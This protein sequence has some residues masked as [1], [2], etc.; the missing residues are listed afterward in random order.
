MKSTRYYLLLIL[1]GLFLVWL[2]QVMARP[3]PIG[4]F[5][6]RA[7]LI[8]GTGILA[9]GSM[10]VAMMLAV[11]PVVLENTLNGLDKMY[12]L[13]KWLGIS[14]LVFAILHWS[15]AKAPRWIY[16]WDLFDLG[17]RGNRPVPVDPGIIEQF[18]H[19]QRHLAERVG[20]V[21]FYIALVLIILALL[22]RFPYHLFFKTHHFLAF[23]YLALVFHAVL[24]IRFYYWSRPIGI[25]MALLMIA[26][27]ISALIVIFHGIG[28][29][30]QARGKVASVERYEDIDFLSIEIDVAPEM[31]WATHQAGQ[32]AFLSFD[33]KK[34]AHPFTI[35]SA[36]RGDHR[37]RFVIKGLG[38]YTRQMTEHLKAGDAVRLE[39]PY[40]RF[41][42][43]GEKSR[44]IWIA[45]GIGITPFMARL[46]ALAQKSDGRTID[47]FFCSAVHNTHFVEEISRL[48]E[49]AKVR[50]HV[51]HDASD[52]FLD[53]A[54]LTQIV[55]EWQ[56]GS[57]WFCGPARFGDTLKNSLLARGL[58]ESQFHQELF[59]M[60]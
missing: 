2:L 10:S 20:E 8:Q 35:A 56:E 24:L 12:R 28:K 29:K 49:A 45:G 32:F 7:L 1:C 43:G 22:R 39:G 5:A 44:Q 27:G 46:D 42:F 55:P 41:V 53:G 48:A 3:L 37:L 30:R 47:L 40:G 31:P 51:M 60:R 33:D 19:S 18:F 21:A 14:A 6:W 23:V 52:G 4:F 57:F 15:L 9:I 25:L 58:A 34:E 13:H 26:G 17:P 38:D 36:A 11:R 16:R 59:V 50:L 54:R